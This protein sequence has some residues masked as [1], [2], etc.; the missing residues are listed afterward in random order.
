[1]PT[2]VSR[3]SPQAYLKKISLVDRRPA[4]HP[5]DTLDGFGANV[6]ALVFE[7][8]GDSPPPGQARRE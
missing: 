5:E 8:Q 3:H 4:S 1:V 2:G 7:G 6:D